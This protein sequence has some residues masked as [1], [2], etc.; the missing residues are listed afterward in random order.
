MP[1]VVIVVQHRTSRFRDIFNPPTKFVCDMSLREMRLI[2]RIVVTIEDVN[3]LLS[4]R[5]GRR[6]SGNSVP[7]SL[8]VGD[9]N[10][11]VQGT[12]TGIWKERV[13]LLI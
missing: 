11:F 5:A 13:Q 12:L 10:S 7:R 4:T 6:R 3:P 2:D 9:S 8:G 1:D